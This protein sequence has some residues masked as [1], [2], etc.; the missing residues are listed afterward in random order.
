MSGLRIWR[1]PHILTESD[2]RR[3][4]MTVTP[5]DCR[6]TPLAPHV[7]SVVDRTPQPAIRAYNCSRVQHRID[8]PV[9]G[10]S[11]L[12][13]QARARCRLTLNH[14]EDLA[15]RSMAGATRRAPRRAARCAPRCAVWRAARCVA[16]RAARCAC[17]RTRSTPAQP[18]S[19]KGPKTKADQEMPA[20]AT[21]PNTHHT[22]HPRRALLPARIAA[23][24]H[25][26][27]SDT[28]SPCLLP[29]T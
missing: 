26:A 19:P 27:D 3:L 2:D 22:R 12:A 29:R 5:E 17:H 18:V 7:L 23:S 28:G 4:E 9:Q 6:L 11:T 16:W 1:R 14:T 15:A 25:A 20:G 13:V 21:A 8:G 24:A 10:E